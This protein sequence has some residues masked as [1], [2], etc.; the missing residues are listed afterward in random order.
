MIIYISTFLLSI[1]FTRLAEKVI[2]SRFLCMLFSFIAIFI[3][4]FVAGVRDP[5]IG[6]DC[7]IN[8]YVYTVWEDTAYI[9]SMEEFLVAAFLG[10]FKEGIELGYLLLNFV[11]HRLG[12]DVHWIFFLSN[13]LTVF[14]FYISAYKNRKNASMALTMVI[15]LLLYYNL[16]LNMVR[17]SIALGFCVLS[18]GYFEHKEWGKLS[19]CLFS[20]LM[21][22]QTVF[23]YIG[24]LLMS[25]I[26]QFLTFK[27]KIRFMIAVFFILSI[28][29]AFMDKL[30][31]LSVQYG[32]LSPHFVYYMKENEEETLFSNSTFIVYLFITYFLLRDYTKRRI[33]RER[34]LRLYPLFIKILGDSTFCLS[35]ISQWAYRISFYFN[36]LVDCIFLPNAFGSLKR[37]SPKSYRLAISALILLLV[38]YWYFNVVVKEV[39]ETYPYT[40][41]ILGI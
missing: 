41:K 7:S 3:P 10:Y 38:F 1:L 40:S 29:V 20:A 8:G 18:F 33:K 9:D 15:F 24:I 28:A 23:I 31:M 5:G 22:H 6:T 12:D 17:Q 27:R 39:N 13:L 30:I 11:S 26:W 16:S 35:L 2:G 14:L 4:A 25:W 36:Y 32:L 21:F 34:E 37:E 19:V